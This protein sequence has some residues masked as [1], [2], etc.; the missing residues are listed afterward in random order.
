MNFS[1]HQAL[2][3]LLEKFVIKNYSWN[4]SHLINMLAMIQLT[5][6]QNQEQAP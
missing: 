1:F 4:F 6:D 5:L 3:G 2:K